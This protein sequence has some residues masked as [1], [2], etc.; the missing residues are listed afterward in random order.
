MSQ[1]FFVSAA[2]ARNLKA[3]ARRR[4]PH[5][6][7]AHLTEATAASLGFRTHAALRAALKNS[8]TAAAQPPCTRRFAERLTA[9][10]HPADPAMELALPDLSVSYAVFMT[11]PLTAIRGPRF[12]AWRN[13]MVSGINAG[14]Q[15]G[16]FG[17]SPNQNYWHAP[18]NQDIDQSHG[19]LV[20]FTFEDGSPAL[21]SFREISGDE[22][23]VRVV[24]RPTS[25]DVDP[26]HYGG[27]PDGEAFAHGWLERRLGAW[28]QD[29]VTLSCRRRLLHPVGSVLVEPKGYADQGSFFL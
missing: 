14:L 17:L 29:A 20:R 25:L 1:D 21:A 18:T 12:R 9:L 15:Q 11:T 27:F 24:L 10:G 28:I 3:I 6:D 19:G 2:S 13:L 22:L 5:I 26:Q 16:L 23:A 7:S 8:P 4:L